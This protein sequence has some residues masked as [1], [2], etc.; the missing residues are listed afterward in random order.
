MDEDG[1]TMGVQRKLLRHASAA[2]NT[3][4]HG[5]TASKPK[6][7]ANGKPVRPVSAASE[8]REDVSADAS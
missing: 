6:A 8:F 2:T 5:S 3:H 1:T 7:K 4:N